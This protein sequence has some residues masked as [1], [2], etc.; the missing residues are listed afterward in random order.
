MIRAILMTDFTEAFPHHLLKGIL[1]YARTHQQW[2]VCRM[3]PSFR[4]QHG[5]DGVLSWALKWKADVIIAQ[6]D[7]TDDVGRFSEKGIIPIAQDYIKPF[8]GI[9]N[10]TSDYIRTGAIAADFFLKN[11][12]RHFAFYGYEDVV[13]S[14]ERCRGYLSE[15]KKVL[16][17][18]TFHSYQRQHPEELWFYDSQPVVEWLRSLPKPVAIFAC[19]DNQGNKLAEICKMNGLRVPED[20]SILGVDNDETMCSM[21]DPPLSSVKL[22]IERA[23]YQ[24]AEMVEAI[25]KAPSVRSYDIFI[26]PIGVVERSSSSLM[27][28]DD[29]M[30]LEAIKYIH[31][32]IG[33]S[34]TVSELLETIPL[35]RR[36]L[37]IR[38]KEVTGK[39][40]HNYITDLRVDRFARQI[41]E[42]DRNIGEIASQYYDVDYNNLCRAFRQK[43]GVSPKEYRRRNQPG[44]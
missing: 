17:E 2:V 18:H 42:S 13:W 38:F 4:Q 30:V 11:G 6:F 20:I 35:S 14:D 15:I 23:G 34:I 10:I 12:F 21:T 44:K 28:T 32:N 5:L 33:Q 40:I 3:P 9:S 31:K 22:D 43:K 36:L 26:H 25:M 19:D 37:E 27:V 41:L 29:N 16:P 24:V 39:S 8:K 1:D 7:D